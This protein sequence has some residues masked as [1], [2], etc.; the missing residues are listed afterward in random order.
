M[1]NSFSLELARTTVILWILERLPNPVYK[2]FPNIMTFVG[3][4]KLTNIEVDTLFS[5]GISLSMFVSISLLFLFYSLQS[6]SLP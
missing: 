4:L 2:L 1:S 6:S 5:K 3:I